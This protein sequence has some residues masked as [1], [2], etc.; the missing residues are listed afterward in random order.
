[1]RGCLREIGNAAGL[2]A[3]CLGERAD[4]RFS[5][6]PSIWSSSRLRSSLMEVEL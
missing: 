2:F 4:L 6:L 5:T 3:V 1:M